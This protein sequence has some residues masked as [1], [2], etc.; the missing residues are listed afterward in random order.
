TYDHRIIQ[1]AE[2]GRFLA[3]IED[4]LQGER[5]FYDGVFASLGAQ[6]GSPPTS[7]AAP[8]PAAGGTATT[9][10]ASLATG[11]GVVAVSVNEE[12]LQAVQAASTLV[13]R[14]RSHGHLAAMLDPLDSE[15]E[16]DP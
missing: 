2:S 3:R 10:E 8:T 1:G 15:P 5:G 6:L 9:A 7:P 13:S 11:D 14:F 4:Y 12:L 16:G